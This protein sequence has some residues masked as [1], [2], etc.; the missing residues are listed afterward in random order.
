MSDI[1]VLIGDEDL[2][3]TAALSDFLASAECRVVAA[4]SSGDVLQRVASERFDVVVLEERLSRNGGSDIVSTIQ[5]SP[6]APEIVLMASQVAGTDQAVEAIRRGILAKPFDFDQFLRVVRRASERRRLERENAV[7][8]KVVAQQMLAGPVISESPLI[9]AVLDK[10]RAVAASRLPVLLTGDTGTGKG[11]M[12]KELHRLSDR[13]AEPFLQVN[14]GA[15]QETLFES[16]L[17]GHRKGAF[18]G[19]TESKPGLFEVADGGTLFLDEVGEL[20]PVMQAKLL[21]VL[22]S[23]EVR[24]VGGTSARR[25][26]V[27]VVAATNRDLADEV[28][29][30]N[31]RQDLYYRLNPIHVTLPPLRDRREDIPL[32]IEFFLSRFSSSRS[33]AKHFTPGAMARLLAHDW[34]GNVRELANTVETAA[35]LARQDEISEADLPLRGASTLL[36][37]PGPGSPV[38]LISLAEVE[39]RH[40]LTIL[41]R[42]SG[43][44]AKAARVL[45]IDIKTLNRKLK[46]YR[47]SRDAARSRVEGY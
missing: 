23:S 35:L 7:L 28:Q 30:G 46:S 12:A 40:I 39:R 44:K 17:F 36:K 24:P 34:P 9:R 33:P 15:L 14:C 26:D 11:L 6:G 41:D 42:V 27:R 16:E 37:A 38:E 25:V 47:G 31:F 10:L 32:L 22:D 5:T 19:A 2:E 45:G 1:S 4:A 20:K 29:K 13:A 21:Q 43:L 8:R 3:L 18:T